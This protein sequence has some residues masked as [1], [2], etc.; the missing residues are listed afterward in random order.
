MGRHATIG[1]SNVGHKNTTLKQASAL[2]QRAR[3]RYAEEHPASVTVGELTMDDVFAEFAS[4]RPCWKPDLT[5]VFGRDM[6][7]VIRDRGTRFRVISGTHEQLKIDGGT[8]DLRKVTRTVA[9]ERFS[10]WVG[11]FTRF[12]SDKSVPLIAKLIVKGQP[13]VKA[14]TRDALLTRAILG[15]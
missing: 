11:T 4:G 13:P 5:G 1:N 7:S 3:I 8:L 15:R 6:I 2:T 14:D 9:G 10:A 12:G